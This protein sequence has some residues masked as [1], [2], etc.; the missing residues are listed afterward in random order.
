VVRILVVPS[1]AASGGRLRLEQLV[2]DAETVEAIA[3]SLDECRVIGTRVLVQPPVY[4]GVTVVARLQARRGANAAR[5]QQEALDALYG[6]LNP[7]TGGPERMGW[8]FGR[9]AHSGEVYAIL[10]R[11]RGI[12]LVDD[13]RLFGANLI[14]GQRGGAVQRLELDPHALV[15]SYEH[16]VL[17]VGG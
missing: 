2:P 12:E 16:Q 5:L 4:L 6:Y 13:V 17:V 1:A 10:Q 8:P 11:L 14:T 15:F 3:R 7:V 9:P